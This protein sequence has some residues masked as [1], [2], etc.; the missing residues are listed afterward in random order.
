[1]KQFLLILS[2][3]LV[4]LS[5]FAQ[6]QYALMTLT[7]NS[8][9][10]GQK[11]SYLQTTS[12]AITTI[13][14]NKAAEIQ[15]WHNVYCFDGN[16]FEVAV[17]TENKITKFSPNGNGTVSSVQSVVLGTSGEGVHCITF[18]NKDLAAV[19][20]KG[21]FNVYFF[22]PS[23]M[24][25]LS[26]K[27]DLN[28]LYDSNYNLQ[29]LSEML[30]R[31]GKLYVSTIH[32]NIAGVY[33]TLK[34]ELTIAVC[35]LATRSLDKVLRDTR[36]VPTGY[37]MNTV[38]SMFI[39]EIGDIYLMGIKAFDTSQ[40][41]KNPSIMFRIKKGETSLDTSYV[42]NVQ[43]ACANR[44]LTGLKYIGNGKAFA[45]AYYTEQ[46]NPLDPFSGYTDP[47]FKYWAVD[48]TT[49]SAQEINMPFH[50]GFLN[51]WMHITPDGKVWA[52]LVTKAESA[53]YELNHSGKTSAK[54][55]TTTGE[56]QGFYPILPYVETGI[57]ENVSSAIQVYPNPAVDAVTINLPGNEITNLT[58]INS[59]GQQVIQTSGINSV[60]VSGISAGVYQLVINARENIYRSTVSISH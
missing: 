32:A 57:S 59:M 39:D 46:V 8:T 52:P 11:V 16:M 50:K 29:G 1:M 42:F 27:I 44:T 2:A 18:I 21:E 43:T 28:S 49:Q 51:N 41:S 22:N 13:N 60:D 24:Q 53:I 19:T 17:D 40:S 9:V 6:Q 38:S 30:Y 33:A 12:A 15:N 55:F 58:L 31:D 36:T 48:M 37:I 25:V 14:N 47:V 56:P 23:T 3:V 54:K 34:E 26:D 10:F 35:D 4:T 5:S 45:C 7:G 20:V